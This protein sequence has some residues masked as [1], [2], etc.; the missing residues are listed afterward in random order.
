MNLYFLSFRVGMTSEVRTL[1]VK[2]DTDI[3]IVY[4]QLIHTKIHLLFLVLISIQKILVNYLKFVD[5]NTCH[6]KKIFFKLLNKIT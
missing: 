5:T 3:N 2:L 6:Y 1:T 4:S